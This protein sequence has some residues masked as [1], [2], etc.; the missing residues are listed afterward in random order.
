MVGESLA[1]LSIL[2]LSIRIDVGTGEGDKAG[3][4][5]WECVEWDEGVGEGEEAI[6]E[7]AGWGELIQQPPGS[8]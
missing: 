2:L 6:V 7:L 3:I 1:V 4:W 8:W 5:E